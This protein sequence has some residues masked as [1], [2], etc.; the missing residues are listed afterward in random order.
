MDNNHDSDLFS[1][2]YTDDGVN[3]ITIEQFRNLTNDYIISDE[4]AELIIDSLFQLCWI[5]VDTYEIN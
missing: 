1:S 2:V 4:E 3:R 5:A